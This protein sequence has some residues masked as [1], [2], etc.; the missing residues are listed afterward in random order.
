VHWRHRSR[1]G[2]ARGYD[3]S[4]VATSGCSRRSG[5]RTT[6]QGYRQG[7]DVGTQYRSAIYAHGPAAGRGRGVARHV[8]GRAGEGGYG[9]ITT[10]IRGPEF[11]FAEDYHQQYLAKDLSGYCP[12]H[13]TGVKLP[14]GVVVTP[15][16]YVSSHN[17]TDR[18]TPT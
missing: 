3:P 8:R 6:T 14:A 4:E 1:R 17:T 5:S 16:Q 7:N 11:Y 10:E 12:N 18:E 13:R 9:S 15:L 2:G